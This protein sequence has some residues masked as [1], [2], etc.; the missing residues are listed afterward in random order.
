MLV[1]GV[2]PRQAQDRTMCFFLMWVLGS[3]LG[4]VREAVACPD[5]LRELSGAAWAG[6]TP[7]QPLCCRANVFAVLESRGPEP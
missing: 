7:G 2:T 5:R 1:N 6:G 4:C 3:H